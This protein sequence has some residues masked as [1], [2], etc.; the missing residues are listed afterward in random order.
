MTPFY[1]NRVQ[2]MPSAA[3]GNTLSLLK[4]D[5]MVNVQALMVSYVD[6][7]K[8]MMIVTLCALPLVLLLRK[9]P[10]HGPASDEATAA[11]ME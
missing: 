8:L 9:P 11:I 6:D 4:L 2:A 1:H 5:A 7:F 3:A 10:R